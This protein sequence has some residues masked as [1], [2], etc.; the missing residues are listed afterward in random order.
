MIANGS[1]ETGTTGA[2]Y[3]P[4]GW[5][6]NVLSSEEEYVA[7][8]QD[9]GEDVLGSEL[10]GSGW[11]AFLGAFVGDFVD[12]DVATFD[13]SPQFVEDFENRWGIGSTFVLTNPPMDPARF[14]ALTELFEDFDAWPTELDLVPTMAS[15]LFSGVASDNFE[16]GWG[17]PLIA[18]ATSSPTFNDGPSLA[19]TSERFE[20][21]AADLQVVPLPITDELE[22]AS[23]HGLTNGWRVTVVAVDGSLPAGFVSGVRYYVRNVSATRFQLSVTA[24]GAVVDFTDTGA[25]E[26]YIRFD[27]TYWWL[28]D[29]TPVI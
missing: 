26:I 12:L 13:P 16:D 8:A 18:I 2:S 9:V 10:F 24:A 1:F 23:P 4:D 7:F 6:L 3:L 29:A 25:G 11:G 20:A 14:D 5:T 15:A 28:L 22:T 19:S 17:F 27:P 21:Q